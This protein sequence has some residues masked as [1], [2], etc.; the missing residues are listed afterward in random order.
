[1]CCAVIVPVL[2]YIYVCD[3]ESVC[4]SSLPLFLMRIEK[5]SPKNPQ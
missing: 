5:C 4:V 2:S 3:T 1:M